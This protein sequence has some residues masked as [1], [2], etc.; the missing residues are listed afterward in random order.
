M[1]LKCPRTNTPLKEITL[2]GIKLDISEK[3]GGVW[4]SNLEIKKLDEVQ[5]SAGDK[6]VEILEN[7]KSENVDF[8]Q[9]IKC[10]KCPDSIMMRNFYSP[11][12][13]F[14]MDTCPT[15]AGI[16]LDPVGEL[17]DFAGGFILEG[18]RAA[19]GG[20]GDREAIGIAH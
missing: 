4:L 6:L 9:R 11:K 1:A 2:D 12:R 10:P 5:E 20:Q 3:C 15:C 16:W 13:A 18:E 19:P 17:G 14:Q 7:F 8:D